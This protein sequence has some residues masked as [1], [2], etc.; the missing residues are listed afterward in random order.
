V[1]NVKAV[2]GRVRDLDQSGVLFVEVDGTRAN[3]PLAD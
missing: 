1:V 3:V 2:A